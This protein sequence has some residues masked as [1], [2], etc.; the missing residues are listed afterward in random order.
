[1]RT[2]PGTRPFR[3]L[4]PIVLL[5]FGLL[6]VQ[7]TVVVWAATPRDLDGAFGVEFG[8]PPETPLLGATLDGSPIPIV[9]YNA[10]AGSDA[11]ASPLPGDLRTPSIGW[12]HFEPSAVS[13]KLRSS[14]MRFYL[15]QTSKGEVAMIAALLPGPCDEL[16]A[17]LARSVDHK[18]QLNGRNFDP[19]G[20]SLQSYGAIRIWSIGSRQIALTC[21]KTGYLLYSDPARVR[22]WSEH[23]KIKNDAEIQRDRAELLAQANR[24]LPGRDDVLLGAFGLLFDV[25]IPD[26]QSFPIAQKIRYDGVRLS[27]PYDKAT[28]ELELANGGYPVRLVGEFKDVDFALLTKAFTSRF[29]MPFKERRNHVQYNINGDYLS[30]QR[31]QESTRIAVVHTRIDRTGT[32]LINPPEP[33]AT[34][35]PHIAEADR[36]HHPTRKD[37]ER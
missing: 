36:L 10:V 29:G 33:R 22:E 12:R 13:P 7:T 26:H 3:L 8:H 28:Y 14:G 5:C 9:L 6:T 27:S 2:T 18:Y 19:P 15:L 35:E 25:P 16:A 24:L 34:E 17:F 32:V 4:K 30:L 11:K 23:L 21:G 20:N 37:E 31:H 1:M